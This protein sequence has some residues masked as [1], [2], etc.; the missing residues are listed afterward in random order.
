[1]RPFAWITLAAALVVPASASALEI[2]T[3]G[4]EV[5]TGGTGILIADIVCPGT[6][7]YGV[8]L[9]SR[10]TLQLNGH[11][12]SGAGISVYVTGGK[13]IVIEGPGELAGADQVGVFAPNNVG[14][15]GVTMRDGVVM[16]DIRE[17]AIALG[18][19]NK[20]KLE[21]DDVT[22]RDNAGSAVADCNGLKLKATD[23]AVTN[24][25]TGICGDAIK[26]KRGTITGNG[27]AGIFSW[28]ARVKLID[29]TVTGND[30]ADNAYD[31]ETTKRPKLV[32]S[33]CDHSVQLPAF[34]GLP[35]PGAPSWGVC[36]GD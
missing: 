17:S 22:I 28:T 21:L 19:G 25:G 15:I 29:S 35:A 7:G 8:L 20:V 3:C 26:V 31:I 12:I 11:S 34:P 5:P 13:R 36:T 2:F 27:V 14:K 9:G 33:S 30:T 32:N 24:N 1:M 4:Q 6:T 16:H 18:Q 10:T 23:F